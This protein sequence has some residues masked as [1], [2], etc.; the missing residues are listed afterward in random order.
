[1][2]TADLEEVRIRRG[3]V[4]DLL[5]HASD[6]A[7]N[8]CCGLLLG[9]VG[10]VERA[11]RAR[12]LHE[13]PA[14][15][16]IDPADHFAAMRE[17]HEAGSRVIGAY[18]SH[19]HSPPVPSETDVAEAIDT[20]LLHIIVSPAAPGAPGEARGFRILAGNFR[21]VRLVLVA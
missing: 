1:M 10:L 14:H 18:H 5:A 2:K 3:I 15:F 16:L 17:A 19:P 12:N 13:S 7:P 11:R 9:K 20:E 4:D 8:E 6:E 21:E